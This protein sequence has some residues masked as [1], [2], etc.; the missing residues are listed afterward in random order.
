MEIAT[1]TKKQ[2]YRSLRGRRSKELLLAFILLVPTFYLLFKTFIFPIFQSLMWSFF[3]YHL[4]DS[5]AVTFVGL[6][7]YSNILHDHDFWISMYYT[8]YFTVFSTALELV[9]GLFSALLLN[10]MFRGR[11]FFRV[12]IIIPW[13]ILTLVNG[14][15]WKWIYQPGYGALNIILHKVH[16]LSAGQNP[17]WLAGG[18]DIINSVIIADVWKMTPYMTLLL[19]AGLQTIP[20][21]LYEAAVIDGAGFWK[22]LFHITIP[23]LKPMLIIALVLRFIAAFRVY[24]ILTVFT[25]D[26]TT[27]ISYLTFNYAFRYF[28]LGKASA[29]AWISTLFVLVL[30]IF[31]IRMLKKNEQSI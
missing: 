11:I 17:L 8:A 30:I 14:L 31:Y 21:N 7:N 9:F 19:L 27:S 1:G 12:I 24:D 5:S 6:Q 4:L 15:L 16:I 26:P 10:Q 29:M 18:Q 28:Y 25:G 20:T 2:K 22:K 3:H 13:A 23:Q